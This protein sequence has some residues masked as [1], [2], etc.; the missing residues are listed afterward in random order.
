MSGPK[1]SEYL[2][3]PKQRELLRKAR[4]LERK[5]NIEFEKMQIQLR[6]L[7]NLT[8]SLTEPAQQLQKLLQELERP[9]EMNREVLE[10]KQA[11]GKM[12]G[13]MTGITARSGFDRL[14][15]ENEKIAELHKRAAEVK[16]K[17]QQEVEAVEAEFKGNMI[18]QIEKGFDLSLK[19]LGKHRKA[20]E[21]PDAVPIRAALQK[22]ADVSLSDRLRSEKTRI[23]NKAREITDPEFLKNFY[24]MTVVPFVKECGQYHREY[25]ELLVYYQVLLQEAGMEADPL[26]PSADPAAVLKEKIRRLEEMQDALAEQEYINDVM[27]EVMAEMG[28]TL[29]GNREV[30]KKS[31]RRFTNELYLFTEG[32]AVNVTYADNGQITME[33]GGLDYLDRIPSADE[34]RQLCDEMRDFCGDYGEIERKLAV[35]GITARR[36]SV[37]PPEEQYAQ[38]I[39]MTEYE[40]KDN[41]DAFQIKHHKNRF[42]G[43]QQRHLEAPKKEL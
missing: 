28:Y 41:V 36:L 20:A 37:L 43:R 13:D 12:A 9:S 4:E 23:E 3:T 5:N 42:S 10:L 15:E 34:S 32:T 22:L 21:S 30:V 31:G 17:L 27:N 11:A 16:D 24:S 29:A 14:K 18:D 26:I 2:L 40:L 39:N 35:R 38:I 7:A 33:L 19:D 8:A 6:E 1:T 25:E